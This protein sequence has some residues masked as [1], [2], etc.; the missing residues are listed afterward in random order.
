[1]KISI[2]NNIL[3]IHFNGKKKEM[4]ETLDVISNNYEGIIKNRE[5]HNFPSHFIPKNH[6]LYTYI[7]YC[8][9]VIGIYNTKDIKHEKLH[10]KYYL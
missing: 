2:K 9:Y 1:M 4:N 6:F 5:G 8:K 10:A 3:I 7:N